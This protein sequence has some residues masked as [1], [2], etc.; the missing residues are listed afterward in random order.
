[1]NFDKQ[2]R[3]IDP[4]LV[5]DGAVGL[6]HN[7]RL[8]SLATI[9]ARATNGASFVQSGGVHEV[10]ITILPTATFTNEKKAV[11]VFD[12]LSEAFASAALA[13][14]GG[15]TIEVQQYVIPLGVRTRFL[16]TNAISW[17][18]ILPDVAGIAIIEGV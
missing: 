2:G 15:Q 16:F 18:D 11:V 14:T 9:Y 17:V 1:M 6:P 10:F 4:A 12:A 5:S 8:N 13:N 7:R 3:L